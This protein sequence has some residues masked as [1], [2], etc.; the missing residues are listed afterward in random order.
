VSTLGNE[1]IKLFEKL[2]TKAGEK[3]ME[4]INGPAFKKINDTVNEITAKIAEEEAAGKSP[5]S[6]L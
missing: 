5:R 3:Q 2:E 6:L 4:F 1:L